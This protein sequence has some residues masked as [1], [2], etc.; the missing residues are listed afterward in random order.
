[1]KKL[2]TF[3][4]C[5]CG[6]GWHYGKYVIAL[7][8]KWAPGKYSFQGL[9]SPNANPFLYSNWDT[10][11]LNINVQD[12][13]E[14]PRGRRE[15]GERGRSLNN[16][17]NLIVLKVIFIRNANQEQDVLV[18]PKRSRSPVKTL[19]TKQETYGHLMRRICQWANRWEEEIWGL[20]P[21]ETHRTQLCHC[22]MIMLFYDSLTMRSDRCVAQSFIGDIS[23]V[24]TALPRRRAMLVCNDTDEEPGAAARQTDKQPR[25]MRLCWRLV[26]CQRG[27]SCPSR[28]GE[29][30][31]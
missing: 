16:I 12:G 25:L 31:L 22:G 3:G 28:K 19:K 21:T 10:L 1:M 13:G 26:S 9:F 23:R 20:Y 7:H 2:L 11:H 17:C 14:V 29:R 5:S 8:L 24:M 18:G 4:R 6:F 15:R 30:V 27:M